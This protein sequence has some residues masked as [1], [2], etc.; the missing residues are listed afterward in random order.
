M[1]RLSVAVLLATLSTT[2]ALPHK[3][4]YELTAGSI[5]AAVPNATNRL[6]PSFVIKAEVLLDRDHFSP[7]QI[8]GRYGDNFRKAL[9][10][11]QQ[12]N[13]LADTGNIN[14]E[15]WTALTSN[16]SRPVLTTY[17]IS[18]TDVAGPFAKRIPVDL[19]L[20]ARVPGLPT[21]ARSRN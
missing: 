4:S 17:T 21:R 8:D 18:E 12:A 5:Q 16:V 7:G 9:R 1:T 19:R 10:A 15:T 2:A 14:A 13:N 20:L 6:D 11:F 3:T